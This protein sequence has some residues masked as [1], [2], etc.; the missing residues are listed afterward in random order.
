MGAMYRLPPLNALKCFEAAARHQ[1]FSKAADELHVTQ[2][3]VSHQI[4]QLEQWF[5]VTLFDRQG[6]LTAPTP[7]G[8]ELAVAL[9]EAFGQIQGAC[10]RIAK[11]EGRTTLTIASIPS[12]AT[13][14]LI[15]RLPDF[16]KRHPGITVRLMH[17]YYDQPVDFGDVD[18]AINYGNWDEAPAGATHFLSGVSVPVASTMYVDQHGPFNDPSDLL[19]TTLLHDQD[20]KSWPQWFRAAGVAVKAS[21][22]GPLFEG[23]N[24][25]HSAILAGQGIGLAPTA[26][27]RG[28]LERG[29]LVKLSDVEVLQERAYFI[30]EPSAPRH[31]RVHEVAV[32]KEWL[33]S[34][35]GVQHGRPAGLKLAPAAT[36]S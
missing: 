15:P 28:D 18:L 13:I 12:V 11:N 10:S 27:L 6:R 29:N 35:A 2:S 9:A 34:E 33:L 17:A 30:T 26:L 8:A 23:F 32:F 1:S 16:M 3:A 31:S 19:R 5:A 7:E 25:L 4:R 22:P 21:L 36:S 20:R 24:M 14:W